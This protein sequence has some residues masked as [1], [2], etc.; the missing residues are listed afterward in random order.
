[1][2]PLHFPKLES[3]HM[4]TTLFSHVTCFRLSQG[5]AFTEM[6]LPLRQLARLRVFKMVI[7][8]HG[9]RDSCPQEV[10]DNETHAREPR[11]TFWARKEVRRVWAEEI[12]DVV[13]GGG[14]E[15]GM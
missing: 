5:M 11:Y 3:L 9:V 6:F 15:S 4:S 2:L 12:R 13:L 14:V 1:M 8:D 10:H 7:T